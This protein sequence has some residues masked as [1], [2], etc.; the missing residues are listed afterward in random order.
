MLTCGQETHTYRNARQK[1]V[2]IWRKLTPCKAYI[3]LA[4][5]QLPHVSKHD[6]SLPSYLRP[7]IQ[8][9]CGF[10][11]RVWVFSLDQINHPNLSKQIYPDYI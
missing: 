2:S 4:S 1:K 8:T 7:S 10:A 5:L 11:P 9:Q 3:S 6:T